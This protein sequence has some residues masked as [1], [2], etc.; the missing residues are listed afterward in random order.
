MRCI[1]SYRSSDFNNVA[2]AI[3]HVLQSI[4]ADVSLL[5]KP[6]PKAREESRRRLEELSKRNSNL[7]LTE[8]VNIWDLLEINPKL[9][10]DG[11][12]QPVSL[13][14]GVT[15]FVGSPFAQH[16]PAGITRNDSGQ[17]KRGK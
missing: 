14:K 16:C 17:G 12:V 11:F 8:N 2:E 5:V 3:E 1:S 9:N 7:I 10:G 15:N 4:P 13:H 6:H